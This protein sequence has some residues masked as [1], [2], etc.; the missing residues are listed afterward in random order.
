LL[1]P[2]VLF[3][4]MACTQA[5]DSAG[6]TEAGRTAPSGEGQADN[7]PPSIPVTLDSD[8]LQLHG[9]FFQAP[10]PELHPTLLLMPGWPG[11]PEDVLGMGARLMAKGINV[12][13]VNPRGMHQSGGET[14]FAGAFR[15]IGNSLR[16]LRSDSV[17]QRNQIDR[18]AIVLG[19]YSWGGGVAMAYAATDTTVRRIVSIAGNDWAVFIR[20]F[21]GDDSLAAEV[22][23]MLASTRA[24]EGPIRFDPEAALQELMEGQDLYGLRENAEELSDRH[25][26]LIGGLDDT[27]VTLEDHLLPFYRALKTAEAE[28]VS[29]SVYQDDHSFAQVRDEMAADI[30]KWITNP[31]QGG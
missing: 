18:K 8:G 5:G 30:A 13:M 11:N 4:A 12:L 15:D 25:I 31:A 19:G 3:S 2:L 22:R 23:A 24:P 14:T 28:N 1:S 10:S 20:E 29:L 9:R 26:L 21:Q 16:W 7:A 17:A 6:S 27:G